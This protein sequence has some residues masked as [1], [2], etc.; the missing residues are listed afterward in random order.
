MSKSIYALIQISCLF[1]SAY[2]FLFSSS[3]N[4]EPNF[5][6]Y[7][8]NNKQNVRILTPENIKQ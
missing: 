7:T 3:T 4:T 2:S 6:L 8:R 1:V 5:Y